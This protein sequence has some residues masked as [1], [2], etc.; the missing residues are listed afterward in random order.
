MLGTLEKLVDYVRKLRVDY[1]DARLEHRETLQISTT[2]GSIRAISRNVRSGV[3]VRTFLNGH[4]GYA[5]STELSW[6]NL[7]SAAEKAVKIAKSFKNERK[8]DLNP[9]VVEKK[10]KPPIKIDPREIDLKEKIDLLLELDKSQKK[11]DNRIVNSNVRY[12]E[13][14]TSCMLVN[15]E[16]SKIEWT[17]IRTGIVA[18]P[19]SFEAGKMQSSYF[20]KSGTRGY[21]LI[22]EIDPNVEGEKVA[23]EAV[24]LLGAEKPPGGYL[25]VIVDPDIAG[26][27]AHEVM[28]H[29]SEADEIVKKRSFL[30]GVVGENVGSELVTMVDDGTILGAHGTIPFDSEGTPSSRTVIIENGIYKGY[31]HNLE[32]AA[33]MNVKPTGNGR[34]QDYNRRVWVRMTNT[35]FEKGDWSLEE[36]ISET[37]EGLLAMKALEGM[38]DPVGGGFEARALK[39]YIIKNGERKA[40][41]RSF[42][43]TGKALDILKT[44]DAVSKDFELQ[45]GYC[46]KGEEDFVP[47]STGGPY[48][49]A[50]ILIGGG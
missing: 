38:E 37:K 11:A 30:T 46:G 27:L 24:E 25:T 8:I 10:Y 44:V 14:Y 29:A 18:M 36:I 15:S 5:S 20:V 2:N 48:M 21:E 47:V 7:K 39:G 16:G 49:R 33:M 45:G 4:W 43:L 26:L 12:R 41:V 28:G 17:E 34:A 19:V 42:T 23:K 22:K 32:T 31:M 40:L 3:S 1:C 9:I 50:K 6:E 35:F 13:L